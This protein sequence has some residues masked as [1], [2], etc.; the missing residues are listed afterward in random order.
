VFNATEHTLQQLIQVA[1]R[2]GRGSLDST[3]IIQAMI[4]HHVYQYLN[5]IDYLQFYK[6][7]IEKRA[8]LRYPPCGM[9]A[10]IELKDTDEQR[11]AQEAGILAQE[12]EHVA[13]TK[14]MDL[15]ILG[16]SKPPVHKIQGIHV[17]KIFIKG[18]DA[19]AI[20]SLFASINKKQYTSKLFFTQ[21]F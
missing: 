4:D 10:E 2:A 5:E 8:M 15:M 19:D 20:G 13:T 21:L 9:L 7:E 12:L 14:K 1:G 17:Q 11:I 3:V 18:S 6:T 16:P